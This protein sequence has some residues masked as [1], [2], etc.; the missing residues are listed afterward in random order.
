[1]PILMLIP[2]TVVAANNI[3]TGICWNNPKRSFWCD[4]WLGRV[5]KDSLGKRCYPLLY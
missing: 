2:D 5:F 4:T 1:M 3:G